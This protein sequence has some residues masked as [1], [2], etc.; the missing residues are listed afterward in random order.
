MMLMCSELFCSGMRS[1]PQWKRA[2]GEEEV[3]LARVRTAA[4]LHM[5]R[6]GPLSSHPHIPF[7]PLQAFCV[8][9]ASMHSMQQSKT[10]VPCFLIIN[11]TMQ[12]FS[13]HCHGS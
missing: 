8:Q 12:P 10:L 9:C 13:R 11:C 3:G 7:R 2:L 6:P 5:L 1:S 4:L